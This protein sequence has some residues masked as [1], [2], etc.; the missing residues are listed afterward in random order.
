MEK[1]KCHICKTKTEEPNCKVCETRVG[2][3]STEQL[4]FFSKGYTWLN[5]GRKYNNKFSTCRVALTN[6]RL[7]VYKIKPEAENPA[8]AVFKALANALS[9]VPCKTVDLC[10]IESVKR[11][12]DKHLIKTKTDEYSVW[13]RKYK[14]FD[15]F[16]IANQYEKEIYEHGGA[17]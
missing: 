14:E 5:D 1:I 10:D 4:V 9:K 11:Y 15:A 2:S 8:F 3:M 6:R 16:F 7:I 17:F 12:G 13:L